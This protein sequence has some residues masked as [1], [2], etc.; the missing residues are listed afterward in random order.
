MI[1]IKTCGQHIECG[2]I[3]VDVKFLYN[4]YLYLN[5]KNYDILWNYFVLIGKGWVI[6][7]LFH[8]PLIN[9]CLC[10]SFVYKI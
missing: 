2:L 7:L 8:K 1:E 3:I 4:F 6:Y 5:K 9:Y 10:G